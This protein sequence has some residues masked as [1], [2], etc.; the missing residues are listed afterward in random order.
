[1]QR[2]GPPNGTLLSYLF[3]SRTR[4]IFSLPLYSRL[5]ISLFSLSLTAL[6]RPVL[7]QREMLFSLSLSLEDLIG[8]RCFSNENSLLLAR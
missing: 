6:E 3:F 4:M 1:M 8:P 5:F 2:E 7:E